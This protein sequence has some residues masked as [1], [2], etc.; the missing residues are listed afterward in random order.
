MPEAEF[1]FREPERNRQAGSWLLLALLAMGIST[2]FAFL[3][4]ILRTPF[5]N[6]GWL[7]TRFFTRALV[8]HVD[9]AV[10][11][12]FLSLA[13]VLWNLSASRRAGPVSGLASGLA[14]ILALAGV[15]MMLGAA[16]EAQ[17]AVMLSN[18]IPVLKSPLFLSGLGSFALA[19]V[20]LVLRVLRDSQNTVTAFGSRCAGV[21]LLTAL[22]VLGWNLSSPALTAGADHYFE[23]LFWGPGHVLQ[24][25]YMLLMLVAWLQLARLAA[26][27]LPSAK[28]LRGVFLLATLPL[29]AVAFIQW[30]YLPGSG[31]YRHAYTNL[32]RYGS[33][34]P[35]LGLGLLL[36][37]RLRSRGGWGTGAGQAWAALAL[38]FSLL[39]F[40]LGL[41]AGSLIRADNVLVTAH[42]HGTVGAVTLSFMGLIYYLLPC[43]GGS[44]PA[45]GW[46][47]LQIGMY[48]SGMLLLIAGLFWSGLHDVPRKTPG[49]P[50]TGGAEIAGMLLMGAGGLIALSATLL[51]LFLALRALWPV[52]QT[53][54]QPSGESGCQ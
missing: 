29:L 16:L 7:D 36:L 50:G 35:A 33:W 9:F 37:F 11:I 34:L 6:P 21:A 30:Q 17:P 4:V 12:W 15:L 46:L 25:V 43:L 47:R 27:P 42:Y 32:M 18:Y 23:D 3:L 48:G 13:G 31:G 26:V 22:L 8:L 20:L 19:V 45:T 1:S 2:L 41:V 52:Q 54:F 51:F 53:L 39:L 49:D 14:L 38:A 5:L 44:R 28:L 24:F 40:C 10:I